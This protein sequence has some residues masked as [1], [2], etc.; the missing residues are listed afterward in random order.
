MIVYVRLI[1]TNIFISI[2]CQYYLPDC[3]TNGTDEPNPDNFFK[4]ANQVDIGRYELDDDTDVTSF[5]I[6][7]KE[8]GIG[9]DRNTTAYVVRKQDFDPRFPNPAGVI[10]DNDFALIFLP[11]PITDI[12]PVE[13]NDD[14]NIPANPGDDVAAIGWGF[15]IPDS[16]GVPSDSDLPNRPQ[17][18]TYEYVPNDQCD[19]DLKALLGP[20]A[21]TSAN[22]MCAYGE[23]EL[24]NAS[25]EKKGTCQGDSGKM[26]RINFQC[27]GI[28]I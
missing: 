18:V 5:Q 11:Q 17:T 9:C 1:C 16:V 20:D 22:Q 12:D 10:L 13:L 15:T 14:L 3:F 21:E 4:Y 7:P 19:I 26:Y 25:N 8:Y 6:C 28:L 24:V 27:F 23:I 2:L